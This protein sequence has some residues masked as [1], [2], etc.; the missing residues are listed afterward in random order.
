MTKQGSIEERSKATLGRKREG[1]GLKSTTPCDACV[2]DSSELTNQKLPPKFTPILIGREGGNRRQ[3]RLSSSRFGD[4]QPPLGSHFPGSLLSLP[5]SSQTASAQIALL[6]PLGLA[7]SSDD[8][9]RMRDI[10]QASER[11]LDGSP[12]ARYSTGRD[13]RVLYSISVV[14]FPILVPRSP[15]ALPFPSL[16]RYTCNE[17]W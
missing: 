13:L 17:W 12:A 15:L 4:V 9:R 7:C 14:A 10:D 3:R 8:R 11:P 1:R 5:S 2:G 6:P 16:S